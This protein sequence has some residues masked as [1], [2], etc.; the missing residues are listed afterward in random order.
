VDDSGFMRLALEE[1]RAAQAAGEV[2]VGAVLVRNGEVIATGRNAP[3]ASHDP[4]AHAEIAALRSAAARLGNYRLDGCE[5]FVTLEP[6]AMCAG[7]M[8]HAR[9]SRV[10]FGA[11]DPKTGVAGSVTN[12]FGET[13][14]NHQTAVQGG[15]LAHECGALLSDFFRLRR[16]VA[17]AAATPLREDALRTPGHRF[18][19][20][21]EPAWEPRYVADLPALAGL[22]MHG[23]DEG[24]HEA[25]VT[26]LC[27]HGPRQWSRSFEPMLPVF[28][29]AGHRVLAPDLPGFGRS[30]KPKREEAHALAW[31]LE[32]LTQWLAHRGVGSFVLVAPPSALAAAVAQSMQE[33]IVGWAELSEAGAIDD[34]PYPDRGHGAGPRAWAKLPHAAA[35]GIDTLKLG[36]PDAASAQ[37]AVGY[38]RR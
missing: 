15:V 3:V 24:P 31:H 36:A 33:R 16:E 30:D 11:A 26:W 22:R 29:A 32:V 12:L 1:A 20:G 38:F 27:L 5:L 4:T 2:P 35:E 8:L 13:R 28:L 18:E 37:A 25:P 10:V 23:L 6:C 17:R 14:L 9:L 19:A 34:A 7:A 21:G